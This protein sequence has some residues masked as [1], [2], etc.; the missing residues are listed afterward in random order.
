[1]SGLRGR[2][3]ACL[4]P[5]LLF[6]YEALLFCVVDGG[7]LLSMMW[8]LVCFK[9]FLTLKIDFH[10]SELILEGEMACCL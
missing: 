9:V 4:F 7:H 8:I 2:L 6:A 5:H 1:M 3:R 10:E